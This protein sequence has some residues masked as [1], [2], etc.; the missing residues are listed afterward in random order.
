MIPALPWDRLA[1]VSLRHLAA[2]AII[3]C[4]PFAAFACSS[5]DKT[6]ASSSTPGATSPA[7]DGTGA[8]SLIFTTPEGLDEFDLASNTSKPLL[9]PDVK[10]TFVLDPALSPDGTLIAYVA[11]PPPRTDGG[12]YDA[13]SDL[14]IAN[15]DGSNPR[16]VF[17]HAQPNQLVR[18]PQWE[19]QTHILAVISEQ[20][21][22]NGVTSVDYILQRVDVTTGA[23]TRVLSDVLAFGLTPDRKR[24]VYAQLGKQTGETLVA[25]DLAGG[26]PTTLVDVDENLAPFNSPRYSPDGNTIAFASADQTGARADL[27][28]VSLRSFGPRPAPALDGLPEDIWTMPASGGTPRRVADIK[29]DLPALTWNGD[30]T[31]IYVIGSLALYDVNLTNGAVDKIG[32][33]SF[34]GQLVWTP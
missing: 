32:P 22:V 20:A 24:A 1:G 28:Y 4:L 8:G 25:V 23:R 16:S 10:D 29:E 6:P 21:T 34:H 11:Q 5:G 7:H 26:V 2:I 31:H 17:L 27:R 18:V 13:G 19:D 33:G 30:G 3:V 14:W 9:R 12:M 15:R